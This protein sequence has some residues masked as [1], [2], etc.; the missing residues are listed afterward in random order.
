MV[1]EAPHTR[2]FVV[3]GDLDGPRHDDVLPFREEL[4]FGIE[5][6]DAD[7][8]VVGYIDAPLGI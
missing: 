1:G 8:V 6:L 4:A 7:I 2:S 5:N 3:L